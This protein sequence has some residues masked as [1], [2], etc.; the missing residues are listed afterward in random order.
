MATA[1]DAR[2]WARNALHGIVDSLYTPFS[3]PDGDDIFLTPQQG[4]TQNG[5]M[6]L[7]KQGTL[8]SFQPVP[9]G[10]MAADL[11]VQR[12]DGQRVLTWRRSSMSPFW[13]RS[14]TVICLR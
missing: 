7:N 6:S 1:K 11:Q 3:G 13:F 14:D 2:Q 10:D 9:Q 4:P 12:Y 8:L 5:V